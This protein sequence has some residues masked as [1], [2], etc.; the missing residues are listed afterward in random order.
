MMYDSKE[1][2]KFDDFSVGE[3]V[4][5]YYSDLKG[6]TKIIGIIIEKNNS[7]IKIFW[8]GN[9]YPT[10]FSRNEIDS[11]GIHFC[12]YKDRK[13]FKKQIRGY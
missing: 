12:K 11:I 7:L 4:V 1:Y 3:V 10:F 2:Y 9:S 6:D 5:N 8:E 13:K